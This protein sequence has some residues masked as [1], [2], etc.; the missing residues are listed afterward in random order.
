VVT[1]GN[2]ATPALQK[3]CDNKGGIDGYPPAFAAGQRGMGQF[4][5]YFC[6]STK[7]GGAWFPV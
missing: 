4:I 5:R 1:V 7:Q 6:Y 2:K 3:D